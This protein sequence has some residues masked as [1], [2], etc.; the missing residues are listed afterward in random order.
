L[1]DV[2]DQRPISTRGTPSSPRNAARFGNDCKISRKTIS[3][4]ASSFK[5]KLSFMNRFC[6]NSR[7][8][9]ISRKVQFRTKSHLV[10]S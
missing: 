7:T 10:P 3:A 8:Q 2:G 5:Y 1:R 4:S 6:P 9:A